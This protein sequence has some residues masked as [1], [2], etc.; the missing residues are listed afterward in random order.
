MLGILCRRVLVSK[1]LSHDR[2]R[3][4]ARTTLTAKVL[5]SLARPRESNRVSAVKE[6]LTGELCTSRATS[7]VE[8]AGGHPSIKYFATVLGQHHNKLRRI[9]DSAELTTAR[10][11]DAKVVCLCEGLRTQPTDRQAED[12]K[13]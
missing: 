8:S 5:K 12:W 13:N 1:P 2:A 6:L 9:T 4:F 7:R 10:S 11:V 3:T